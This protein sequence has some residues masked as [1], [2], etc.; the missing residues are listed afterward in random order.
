MNNLFEPR[1]AQTEILAY[2]GGRMG[3]SAV[4]GA[5]KTWTLSYLAALLIMNGHLEPD[6]EVLVVTLVNSAVH[7]F[8]QRIS[9]FLSANNLIPSLGYRV[10]T[11]HGLAHDIVKERPEL[12]GLDNNFQIIDEREAIRIREDAVH[13]WLRL[14]PRAMDAFLKE[15]LS[16]KKVGDLYD[17][18]IPMLLADIALQ[19]IRSSKDLM[20]SPDEIASRL[21]S[22][23]SDFPLVDFGLDIYRSYQKNLAFRGAVDFDDLI[24]K[25]YQI[26]TLDPSLLERL[27]LK[28]PFILEDEA[29]DSSL[30]QQNILGLLASR[31]GNFNW[32]RVGDPNQAIYESF[33]TADPSL[34]NE[35]IGLADFSYTLPNSGRNTLDIINLANHLVNWCRTDHPNREVRDALYPNKIEPTPPGDTQPNPPNQPDAIHIYTKALDPEEEV[36]QIAGSVSRWLAAHPNSTAAIL[37]PRNDRGKKMASVLRS[38]F[39]VEPVELLNSSLET[40]KTTGAIVKILSYLLDPG[41]S[42]KLAEAFK[43]IHRDHQNDPESWPVV[44]K[45]AELLRSIKRPELFT[46]PASGPGWISSLV[47]DDEEYKPQLLDFRDQVLR[48]HQAALLPVDQLILTIASELFTEPSELSLAHQIANFERRLSSS[49]PDWE[50]PV[51]L[52][53]LRALARNERR[54]FAISED[55]EFHP[56][57]HKG[58]VVITTAHKAKG[59]EWDRVYLM[60]ANNYN[61]PSGAD[62]DQYIAERWF[63][64][65][66]LNL[67]AETLAQLEHLLNPQND[68]PSEGAASK[69]ARLEYIRERLRLF[70]VSITR[71]KRELIITWNTGR[72]GNSTPCLAFQC[73]A[74]FQS[75]ATRE[76][77]Q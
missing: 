3:V 47:S 75:T 12:A 62:E 30:L 28:W 76:E 13:S 8:S 31:D 33:T 23:P 51:L 11:L 14:N 29:Q 58:K 6:Q 9:Q 17:R 59:L 35:F 43:V 32:V 65:D 60:S 77:A 19:F 57:E 69:V 5:G 15:G 4:P 34:L 50:L 53:E 27:Q 1:P 40:R 25:A 63:I 18:Q 38:Q 66:N 41:S 36:I 49:H 16:E 44:E 70:Y 39:Q 37:A 42:R 54:F 48:W 22:L 46:S 45:T 67:P 61:F 72:N 71:A 24:T 55:V 21:D 52:D 73:L 7:N 68:P 20:L 74:D 64:R 26:L 2:Q 56:E 10:R